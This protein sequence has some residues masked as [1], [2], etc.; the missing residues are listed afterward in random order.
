MKRLILLIPLL[1]SCN[2]YQGIKYELKY[3]ENGKII[4]MKPYED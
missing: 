1:I 3:D 4:T 2:S